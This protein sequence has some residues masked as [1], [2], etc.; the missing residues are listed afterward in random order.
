M[1]F[2][3][4][5]IDYKSKSKRELYENLILFKLLSKPKLVS[6]GKYILKICLFL[7][8]P[9]SVIIKNTIFK[10]FCGGENINESIKVIQTLSKNNIKTILDYSVEGQKNEGASVHD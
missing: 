3:D 2:D 6:I 7:K 4:K 8:I 1:R 5:Y 9:I 10:H